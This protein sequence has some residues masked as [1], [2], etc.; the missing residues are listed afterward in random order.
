MEMAPEMGLLGGVS[1]KYEHGDAWPGG[2][3]RIIPLTYWDEP[4]RHTSI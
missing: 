4:Q 1:E 2:Y 3:L